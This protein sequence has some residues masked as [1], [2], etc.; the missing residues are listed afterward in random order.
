MRL[1]STIWLA[2]GG[3]S[4]GGNLREALEQTYFERG[5][6]GRSKRDSLDFIAAVSTL[7]AMMNPRRYY[8]DNHDPHRPFVHFC[9]P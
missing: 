3:W 4:V 8:G 5:R 6:L 2:P 1:S 9:L 7:W